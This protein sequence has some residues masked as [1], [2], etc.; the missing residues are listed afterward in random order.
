MMAEFLISP[1]HKRTTCYVTALSGRKLAGNEMFSY[2]YA[3][4][5]TPLTP[6]TN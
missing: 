1:P 5:S 3:Y 4:Q 6:P 2:V